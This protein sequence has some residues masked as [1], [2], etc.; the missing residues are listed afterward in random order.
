MAANQKPED[1]KI[2]DWAIPEDE[3]PWNTPAA[4]MADTPTRTRFQSANVI[5]LNQYRRRKRDTPNAD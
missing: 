1:F 2:E 5:E 3:L 4:D